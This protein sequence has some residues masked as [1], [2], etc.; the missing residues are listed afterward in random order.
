[1]LHANATWSASLRIP[2]NHLATSPPS[3]PVSGLTHNKLIISAST[4]RS[5]PPK[6]SHLT[7]V[8]TDFTSSP[9]SSPSVPIVPQ[10]TASPLSYRSGTSRLRQPRGDSPGWVS[11]V[12][13]SQSSGTITPTK[14]MSTRQ[15]MSQRQTPSN[16]WGWKQRSVG[17]GK[18]GR[19]PLFPSLSSGSGIPLSKKRS[20]GQLLS[21]IGKGLGRMGSVMRRNTVDE[22]PETPSKGSPNG[23]VDKQRGANKTWLKKGTIDDELLPEEAE[24]SESFGPAQ[25]SKRIPLKSTQQDEGDPGIG[26]PFNTEVSS[27][28]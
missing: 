3:S 7:P 21:G 13:L 25:R 6:P 22:A 23:N 11:T 1:M 24:P 18:E 10:G 14:E 26:R 15:P 2:L 16:D 8:R 20:S 27:G 28:I 17:K 19:P 4:I 5:T 12:S 9:L